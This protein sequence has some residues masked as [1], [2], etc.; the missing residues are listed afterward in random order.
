MYFIYFTKITRFT[1]GKKLQNTEAMHAIIMYS[2][3]QLSNSLSSSVRWLISAS[4]EMAWHENIYNS[5]VSQHLELE[6]I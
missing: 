1:K 5:I 2:S 4:F 6:L 3:E